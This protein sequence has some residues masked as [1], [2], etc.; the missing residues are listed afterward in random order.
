MPQPQTSPNLSQSSDTFLQ[1]HL[2]PHHVCLAVTTQARTQ[3]SN[4][5]TFL[6]RHCK[7]NICISSAHSHCTLCT[8][9]QSLDGAL[10]PRISIPCGPL[11]TST[12]PRRPTLAHRPVTPQRAPRMFRQSTMWGNEISVIPLYRVITH[13]FTIPVVGPA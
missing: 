7:C 6:P 11:H 10:T 4:L 9:T 2:E 8:R 1:L 5:R 12:W 13:P 3:F